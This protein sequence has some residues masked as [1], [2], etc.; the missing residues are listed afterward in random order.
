[1][2]PFS[3]QKMDKLHHWWQVLVPKLHRVVEFLTTQG[4]AMAAR[5]F[6]GFLCV[7]LLPIAEYAKFVVVFGFLGTITLLMDISLSGAL[8]PLVGEHIDDRQ[9]IA[10]YVASL[11]QLVH[12]L[13]LVIAPAAVICYPLLVRKQQWSGVVVATMLAVLLVAAWFDRI[14]GTYGAVLI[15]RRDRAFWYRVQVIS[16]LSALVL[17]GVFW[18]FHIFTALSA[19]LISVAANFYISV[20]YYFRAQSLLVVRGCPSKEKRNAII[21]LSLPSIPGVIFYAFQGEVSLILITLFGHTSAVASVGALSRLAQMFILLGQMSPLLIE[22]Y[23]ARLPE[24]RLKR[25]YVGALILQVMFCL[26]AVGLA[27]YFPGLFLWVLGHKYSGLRYEVLLMITGSSLGYLSGVLWMIHAA[28]KFVYWWNGIAAISLIIAVQ[29]MFIWKVD[30]STV[31]AVL[32]LNM[33]TAAVGLLVN[34]A[35]GI[36]GFAFGPRKIRVLA[37][38]H[39]GDNNG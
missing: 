13:Y 21:H 19:I 30:L 36:F 12:R 1:M 23:F 32:T 33:V 24:A 3:L 4:I 10:D 6:Y 26:F 28:R 38:V 25:S 18:Y 2:S 9:L 11:R 7:R 39:A 22:P 20:A 31:R 14:A 37:T 34:L 35:T 27:R 5:L 8:L 15:V 16:S 29:A 17:L